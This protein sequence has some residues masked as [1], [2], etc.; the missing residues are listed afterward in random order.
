MN[1]LAIIFFAL[2]F[3]PDSSNSAAQN[4]DSLQIGAKAPLFSLQDQYDE[5]F[6]LENSRN[7][8]L[9]LL[10]GDHQ[11]REELSQWAKEITNECSQKVKCIFI[12]SF[13]DIPFFLKGWIKGK[14]KND[15]TNNKNRSD[16]VFLDWGGKVFRLYESTKKNANLI[17]IDEKS[18]IHGIERGKVS[19]ENKKRLFNAIDNLFKSQ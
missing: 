1:F 14:F 12:I 19:L 15:D 10:I 8:A 17:L 4:A 9:I 11:A 6:V 18:F 13:P 3:F 2:A 7:E 5:D 16:S